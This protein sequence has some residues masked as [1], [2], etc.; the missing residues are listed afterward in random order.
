MGGDDPPLRIAVGGGGGGLG[1]I[2]S[3]NNFHIV[4][5][6]EGVTHA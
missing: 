5:F 2:E 4:V 1:F 3:D 6:E